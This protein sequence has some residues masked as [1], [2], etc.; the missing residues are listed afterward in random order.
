MATTFKQKAEDR[1]QLVKKKEEDGGHNADP[2]TKRACTQ[3]DKLM[4]KM[5]PGDLS[6]SVH[7]VK[8]WTRSS[9][10]ATILLA[11]SELDLTDAAAQEQVKPL[12]KILDR[13]WLLPCHRQPPNVLQL[14]LRFSRVMELDEGSHPPGTSTEERL[15]AVVHQ[16]HDSEGLSQRHRMDED[17]LR[18]V[19]NLIAGSS[20]EAREVM[21]AHLD[22]FKWKEAALNTEQLRSNRWMIGA[23]PK[24]SACPAE[25]RRCLTVTPQSQ[26]MHLK[27]IINIFVEGGRRLTPSARSRLRMSSDVFDAHADYA[28][29][30]S[31][32]LVEARQLASFTPE[33]EAQ[34]MKAFYQRDYKSDVEAIVASKLATWKIQHFGLWADVVETPTGPPPC[35]ATAAE[36]VDLEDQA[37][38]ARYREVR[39][40]MA[41]DC[42]A[43]TLYNSQME[44]NKRRAHVVH[45][46]RQKG[47]HEVGAELCQTFMTK[48][49]R[50]SL[51]MEKCFADPCADTVF[52]NLAAAKK[53][54]SSLHSFG[55]FTLN[56]SLDDL[57]KNR[58][59]PSAYMCYLGVPDSTLP[60]KGT[61]HR[62]VRGAPEIEHQ[63]NLFCGSMLWQRQ[64]L[65][66]PFPGAL[67]EKEFVVPGE[68]LLSNDTRRNLTDLQETSQWIGGGRVPT[69]ILTAL[70][71]GVKAPQGAVVLHPTAYDG[72]LELA[73]MKLGHAILSSSLIEANY[74]CTNEIVKSHLLQAWKS[75]QAPMD[76]YMPRYKKDPSPEDLPQGAS[77][78]TLKIC[79]VAE[80]SNKLILPKDIRHQ[81]LSCPI[82][83][84][85]WRDVLTNFD[86]SWGAPLADTPSPSKPSPMKTETPSPIK[87]EGDA[88][89]DWKSAFPGEPDMFEKLKEK[90]GGAENF[91][92]VAGPTSTTTFIIAPGPSL[93][94]HA[95]EPVKLP[96][97]PLPFITHGWA[98]GYQVRGKQSGQSHPLFVH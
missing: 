90:V 59:L 82:W 2:P 20:N 65:P 53:A 64:S 22:R 39:A 27:L 91:T 72:C 92:E 51:L 56:L 25:L 10:V 9:V 33:K 7:Q 6:L 69:A 57:H 63:V 95:K 73:G 46:M 42:A 45:V 74:K 88:E 96:C 43:M 86:K 36:L 83:G 3:V 87:Q 93:Y 85:E 89:Y 54:C 4:S 49:C 12:V 84:Q 30:Y 13:A 71:S 94:V 47:Q 1:L 40:K 67:S 60:L 52:R 28:C 32:L 98:E 50:V 58:E 41:Q 18:S 11:A 23:S 48:G 62:S 37:Q 79:Q 81:F 8:G 77:K 5:G 31:A 16:F 75:N 35:V 29:I 44:E 78:P 66:T 15:M 19:Y 61:A 17:K 14:A 38:A 76:K 70:F 26:V 24:A 34:I 55:P 68:S 21:R 97:N 80:D